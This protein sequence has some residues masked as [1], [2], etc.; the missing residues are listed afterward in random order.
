MVVDTLGGNGVARLNVWKRKTVAFM[1]ANLLF[2]LF[3]HCYARIMT[4]SELYLAHDSRTFFVYV[5]GVIF[6]TG[7]VNL[8]RVYKGNISG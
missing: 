7:L 3:P 8:F 5:K 2:F 4:K 1:L 6:S